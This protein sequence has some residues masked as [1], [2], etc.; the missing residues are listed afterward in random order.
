MEFDTFS[1]SLLEPGPDTSPIDERAASALQDAHMAYLATLHESGKLQ[2]AGPILGASDRPYRGL[3]LHRL[4]AAEVRILFEQDP[5]V[6]AGRLTVRV[7]TWMVPR[8]AVE[9]SP[10]R[11]PHSQ[12]EL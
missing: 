4:P 10:T 8:G 9:F 3:C 2:A 12:S 1:V 6:R 11:F 5:L 7:L